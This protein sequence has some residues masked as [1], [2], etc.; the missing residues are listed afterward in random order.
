MKYT[1]CFVFFLIL[2]LS[3]LN[4]LCLAQTCRSVTTSADMCKYP[5]GLSTDSD[6]LG[7]CEATN[8]NIFSQKSPGVTDADCNSLVREDG[9]DCIE[10]YARMIC[11]RE[12]PICGTK[13]CKSLC[14]DVLDKCDKA[15]DAGCFSSINFIC[16]SD[17]S[18]CSAW[19]VNKNKLPDPISGPVDPVD[20][21]QTTTT[22]TKPSDNS[23][24]SDDD[25]NSG[26]KDII[27][28]L[29]IYTLICLV[30]LILMFK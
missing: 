12:C 11:S 1:L 20:P 3:S 6:Q 22:T 4:N 15:K 2:S 25:D 21:I 26:C 29:E 23:T 9:E 28:R 27:S 18:D 8:S 19:E 13:V 17:N 5:N 24:Q 16:D 10:L 14:D 30:I 7:E